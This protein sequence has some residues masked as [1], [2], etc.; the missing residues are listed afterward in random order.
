[1]MLLDTH[2]WAWRFSGDARLPTWMLDGMRVNE[3]AGLG[4]SIISC[5]EIAKLVE[6]GKV[7]L[8]RPVEERISAAL[9]QP[10]VRPLDLTVPIAVESTRLPPPFHRD[11]ADQLNV[12][13]ARI[14]GVPLLT[15]DGRIVAYPHVETP[16]ADTS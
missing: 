9:A 4:V 15:V 5:W 7:V 13:T 1:M 10:A 11:P 16:T 3:G 14:L 2:I 12:A 8:D 6:V